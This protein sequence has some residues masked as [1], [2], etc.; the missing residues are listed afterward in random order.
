MP[1][2]DT[3]IIAFGNDISRFIAP[4]EY[5]AYIAAVI[6]TGQGVMRLVAHSNQ[7]HAVPLREALGS[8]LAAGLLVS[9]GGSVAAATST[10]GLAGGGDAFSYLPSGSADVAKDV[11]AAAYKVVQVFGLMAVFKGILLFKA[12]TEGGGRNQ[13]HDHVSSG[14]V[15]FFGGAMAVHID[16]LV[17]VI[18]NTVGF[19]A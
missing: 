7:P 11:F 6:F 12:A 19:N 4:I 10:M 8:F 2:L 3:S 15:H 1:S 17:P 16:W 14:L 13:G 18:L 5:F 9:I